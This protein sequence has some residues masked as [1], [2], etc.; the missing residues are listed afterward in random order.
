MGSA[1]TSLSVNTVRA[2]KRSPFAYNGKR[3]V[4]LPSVTVSFSYCQTFIGTEPLL[5]ARHCASTWVHNSLEKKKVG[6]FSKES[7]TWQVMWALT[8]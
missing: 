3:G 6:S 7:A 4:G 8:K 5:Y 2:H 1:A